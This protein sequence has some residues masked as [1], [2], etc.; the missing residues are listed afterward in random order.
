MLNPMQQIMYYGNFVI[1]I[2]YMRSYYILNINTSWFLYENLLCMHAV[3]ACINTNSDKNKQSCIVRDI[4][5][6]FNAAENL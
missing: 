4:L 5:R 6:T 3:G 1:P 2:P